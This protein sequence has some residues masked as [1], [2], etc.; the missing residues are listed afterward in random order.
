MTGET[1]LFS[2]AISI[3]SISSQQFF[4]Y[5]YAY[6]EC[7]GMSPNGSKVYKN[8]SSTFHD[9]LTSMKPFLG[10]L[11]VIGIIPYRR[12]KQMKHKYR[13]PAFLIIT[14][15]ALS[16]CG[17]SKAPKIAEDVYKGI[18]TSTNDC[19]N[20]ENLSF[21]I[22]SQTIEKAIETHNTKSPV[23]PTLRACA[24]TEGANK[25]ERDINQKYR[26]RLMA[27]LVESTKPPKGTPLYAAPKGEGG[28]RDLAQTIYLETDLKLNFS[29]KALAAIDLHAKPNRKRTPF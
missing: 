13:S 2:E 20:D 16:G 5:P 4:L 7:L 15:L 9:K 18:Y 21:E 22:C 6:H 17:G 25:C 26:P 28:F 12:E 19:A 24:T 1:T 8:T 23:Y 27:Y 29:K 11:L 14:C 10:I 3:L